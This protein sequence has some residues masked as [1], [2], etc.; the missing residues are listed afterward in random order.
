MTLVAPAI[1]QSLKLLLINCG[2][3]LNNG[4][5]DY[6]VPFSLGYCTVQKAKDL[7]NLDLR[8]IYLY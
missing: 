2:I 4:L 7:V 8:C 5:K 1:H 6:L 3:G